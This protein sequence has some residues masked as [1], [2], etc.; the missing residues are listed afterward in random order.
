MDILFL[1]ESLESFSSELVLIDLLSAVGAIGWM[2]ASFVELDDLLFGEDE[3][4]DKRKFELEN[5][6]KKLTDKMLHFPVILEV[7][8]ESDLVPVSGLKKVKEKATESAYLLPSIIPLKSLKCIFISNEIRLQELSDEPYLRGQGFTSEIK[9]L[10]ELPSFESFSTLDEQELTRLSE[11]DEISS[12]IANR[13]NAVCGV[14][15]LLSAA[16]K[17]QE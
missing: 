3:L 13:A 2:A 11:N 5:E 8:I 16:T 7:D 4:P 17:S 6:K 9:V 12:E 1:L 10:E 14:S 15:S